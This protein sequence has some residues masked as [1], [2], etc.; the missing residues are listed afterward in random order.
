M[1]TRSRQLRSELRSITKGSRSIADFIARIR[2]IPESLMSIGD[3]V[4]H[5]DLI[6]VVLEA[7][8]EEFNPIVASVNSQAEIVSLDELESQLLTQ[9]ARNE[10]FK[11]ALVT[12]QAAV[13]LTQTPNPDDKFQA[14]QSQIGPYT[15]QN[16][17]FPN[18][19]NSNPQYQYPG[20]NNGGRSGANR[21]C[22]GRF[23]GRGGRGNGRS[24]IQCQI[25][26]K[27]G[28]D[29]SYCY[30]RFDGANPY[31]YGGY[32]AQN[33]YGAPPNVWMRNLPRPP[34][35]NFNA[36][37]A[38]PPQFA[39]PRPQTPQAFLT[40][41]EST[42]SSSFQNGWYPDSG[43]TH[44][45]TPDANNLMDFVSLSGSDQVHIGNGQ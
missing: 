2:T 10:K 21:G 22:G 16:P 8:P 41:N 30:Y 15:D 17:N 39:N 29:A 27:N 31:G 28:H 34:Q 9:E 1:R 24:S 40:G 43:A 33:G 42:A 37:P 7:L 12:E 6:E 25:C 4:A 19:S 32:G 45:V 26:Y 5:R 14:S 11:K 13:N 36:R 35:P 3:P 20:F 23:R 44:H 38:F 18:N